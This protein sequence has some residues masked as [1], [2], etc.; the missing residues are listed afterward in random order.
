M[1]CSAAT[2][3]GAGN[4]GEQ[5]APLPE[6]ITQPLTEASVSRVLADA[7]EKRSIVLIDRI[8]WQTTDK[9]S[10]SKAEE[11]LRGVRLPFLKKFEIPIVESSATV[12]VGGIAVGQATGRYSGYA[13][14][15]FRKL[16]PRKSADGLF[17]I[18]GKWE[19]TRSSFDT[20]YAV[21][22]TDAA[23][24][25]RHNLE[26]DIQVMNAD[27]RDREGATPLA[28]A[29]IKIAIQVVGEPPATAEHVEA[30]YATASW[31]SRQYREYG[32]KGMSS[33][34]SPLAQSYMKRAREH[35]EMMGMYVDWLEML[36]LGRAGVLSQRARSLRS[37]MA[38][39]KLQQWIREGRGFD[40]VPER[41]LSARELPGGTGLAFSPDSKILAVGVNKAVKLWDVQT[42]KPKAALEGRSGRVLSVAFSPDGTAVAGGGYGE[43]YKIGEVTVW[44]VDGGVRWRAECPNGRITCVAFSPDGNTLADGGSGKDKNTG[45]VRL[46]DATTGK[47]VLTLEG[48]RGNV[49]DLVFSRDGSQMASASDDNTAKI[50]DFSAGE[51]RHSYRHGGGH[52]FGVP[53]T[54]PSVKYVAF[55]PDGQTLATVCDGINLWD[56]ASGKKLRQISGPPRG[57]PIAFMPDGRSLV[58]ASSAINH[59]G[60]V[61]LVTLETGSVKQRLPGHDTGVWSLALSPDGKTLATADH[62]GKAVK[63]VD[64]PGDAD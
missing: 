32:G 25:G 42:L 14:Q 15:F 28:T 61:V 43:T 31:H 13:T 1:L 22:V 10:E 41:N 38:S 8:A 34:G 7:I 17:P 46:R 12:P 23:R 3:M 62:S 56:I 21:V 57:S 59:A 18:F 39:N 4:T 48:H 40:E 52:K 24:P 36:A 26:F 53:M 54:P 19:V 6:E 47:L 5:K 30:V 51:L 35:A 63:L 50:W 37:F 49:R 16:K 33:I 11:F 60:D 2:M 9:A 58:S 45:E 55:S 27:D 20:S 29:E 64:I 44:S